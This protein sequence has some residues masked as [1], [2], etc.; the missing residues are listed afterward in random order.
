MKTE[1]TRKMLDQ[2]FADMGEEVD[3]RWNLTDEER[4]SYQHQ[5]ITEL[6]RINRSQCNTIAEL[7]TALNDIKCLIH[8]HRTWTGMGWKQNHLGDFVVN[9]IIKIIDEV[10]E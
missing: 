1:L 2:F 7:T 3:G 8:R 10:I 4:L 5:Q 6:T 9:K